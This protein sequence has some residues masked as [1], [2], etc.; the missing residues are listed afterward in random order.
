MQTTPSAVRFFSKFINKSSLVFNHGNYIKPIN[1]KMYA[2]KKPTVNMGNKGISTWRF[3]GFF[4][5][6][7]WFIAI[8]HRHIPMGSGRAKANAQIE[9]FTPSTEQA[10]AINLT[11][12][13][14]ICFSSIHA[15]IKNGSA[16]NAPHRLTGLKLI[17]PVKKIRM[18]MPSGIILFF[19]SHPA[20]AISRE[21]KNTA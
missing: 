15:T 1:F 4:L 2:G 10:A 6:C 17:S 11:S 14:P 5:R 20:A 19:K 12:P 7:K 9:A 16:R 21:Q 3:H 8:F 18:Q 13:P